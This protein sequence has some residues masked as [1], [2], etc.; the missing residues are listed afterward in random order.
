[1]ATA[2]VLLTVAVF[3]AILSAFVSPHGNPAAK[4]IT[5]TQEALALKT[6]D[7]QRETFNSG[8]CELLYDGSPRT[9]MAE[10]SA[11]LPMPCRALRA[12]LGDWE[13][14]RFGSFCGETPPVAC[15]SGWA[16]F[17]NGT[18]KISVFVGFKGELAA[19]VESLRVDRDSDRWIF[20]PQPPRPDHI[21]FP[22]YRPPM[23]FWDP[24]IRPQQRRH[25][26]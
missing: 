8:N 24:P 13:S 10:L 6:I 20:P 4:P 1:M 21:I 15:L 25:A 19:W 3:A 7:Q 2:G 9:L 5:P 23:E 16:K 11:A 17:E 18:A 14:F 12:T 22:A 26:G